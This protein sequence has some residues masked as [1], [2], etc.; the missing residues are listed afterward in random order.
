MRLTAPS[1]P[2]GLV[3]F[4]ALMAAMFAILAFS[5]DSLLPALPPIGAEMSPQ[6]LNRA[7]L[8]VG[9]FVLGMGVGQL[10]MGPASDRFGRRPV[11][12]F[13]ITLYILAA[14]AALR[15]D[16][17]TTLLIWRFVQGFGGSAPRTVG[18]AITRD[19]YSGRMMAR[20]SSFTFMVFVMVPAIAPYIGQQVIRAWDW[21]AMFVVYVFVGFAVGA[22]FLSRQPETLADDKRKPFTLARFLRGVREVLGHRRVV[23]HIGVLTL[24]FSL[25]MA[26]ISS[27]QPIFVDALG[28]GEQFPVYFAAMTVVS[29]PAA[30]LNARLVMR[31]GMTRLVS[32]TYAVQAVVAS[33]LAIV[34]WAGLVPD[35]WGLWVFFAWSCTVFIMNGFNFGNLNALAMEPLGHV[36]G[37]ASALIG[38]ISTMLSVVIAVPI[39]LAFNGTPLPMIGSAA[40]LSILAWLGMKWAGPDES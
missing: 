4:I 34:W 19:L 10:F 9:V 37:T 30:L 22:W 38:A 3:E 18:V 33:T 32:L 14:L 15:A 5:I 24:G 20:V 8:V 31:L 28:A 36:A 1:K 2:L 13:G 21:R 11:V 39:G 29:S 6:D 12:L 26:Y 16:S 23:I 35:A 17:L 40:V 7:Q 25:L 27:A